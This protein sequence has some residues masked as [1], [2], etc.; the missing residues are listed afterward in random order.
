MEIRLSIASVPRQLPQRE[1]DA[2][3]VVELL[4][5]IEGAEDKLWLLVTFSQEPHHVRLHE[6]SQLSP[7]LHTTL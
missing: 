5:L 1:Q 4:K 3:L 7:R 2:E 6:D